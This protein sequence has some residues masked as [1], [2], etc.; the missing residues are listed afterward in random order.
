[1]GVIELLFGKE[2]TKKK[3]WTTS[4]EN[5]TSTESEFGKTKTTTEEIVTKKD[6]RGNTI[7]KTTTT[8]QTET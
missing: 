1:M 2:R 6:A 3:S 5:K 8:K 4:E 7:S